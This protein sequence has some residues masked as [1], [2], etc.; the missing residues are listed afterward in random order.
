MNKAFTLIELLVVIAVVA[1]LTGL[2]L[3]ALAGAQDKARRT[4]CANNCRQLTM[5][6]TIYAH[7]AN[8]RL[9]YNLGLDRRQPVPSPNH[10]L[11]WVNN[12]MT[13]ELDPDNTNTLFVSQSPLGADL[14]NE[15]GVFKCPADRVLSAVQRRAGWSGRVRSVSMNAM[16]GDA[17]PNVQNGGNVLNPDYEQFL[18]LSDIPS[19]SYILVILEEHPDSIGD[20]YFFNNARVPEWIHLPASYHSGSCNFTFAD[21]HAES[22]RWRFPFTSPP[23]LPD[24][25]PLPSAVPTNQLQ[26]FN[27]VAYRMSYPKS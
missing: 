15:A 9:V 22:H 4:L 12:I 25:A 8:D 2:L 11:N 1:I 13:W 7:D 6:W 5:A 21:G 20:G 3:P 19:P 14:G 27:W 17:G 18:K 26:D 23:N 16:V 10:N 24:A